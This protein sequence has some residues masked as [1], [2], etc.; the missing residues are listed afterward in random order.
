MENDLTDVIPLLAERGVTFCRSMT[1]LEF[2][3][4]QFG[5]EKRRNP[6][7][8]LD[9]CLQNNKYLYLDHLADMTQLFGYLT[10]EIDIIA[11]TLSHPFKKRIG[12]RSELS[13]L[14][15][16]ELGANS[17]ST[18]TDDRLHSLYHRINS[19][20]RNYPLLNWGQSIDEVGSDEAVTQMFGTPLT[21][22]EVLRGPKVIAPDSVRK[23]QPIF[24]P[25]ASAKG[26]YD[27]LID[28]A[29]NTLQAPQAPID[30]ANIAQSGHRKPYK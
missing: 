17:S 30:E 8:D 15:P 5:R 13:L 11:G 9:Y 25:L 26:D 10:A 24:H 4:R 3:V 21:Y 29:L 6:D 23:P 1:P 2:M 22:R 20:R 27:I 14:K 12:K 28:S 18:R 7:F 19:R 16:S